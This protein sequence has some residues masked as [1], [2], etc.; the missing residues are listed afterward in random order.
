ML[1]VFHAD[2]QVWGPRMLP[3]I[4]LFDIIRHVVQAQTPPARHHKKALLFSNQNFIFQL[5]GAGGGGGGGGFFSKKTLQRHRK[6]TV[7]MMHV[8]YKY[9]FYKKKW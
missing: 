9:I 6:I 2:T 7:R 3:T 5:R 4:L 1:Y 8:I